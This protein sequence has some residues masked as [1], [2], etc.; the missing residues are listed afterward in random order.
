MAAL[1]HPNIVHAFSVDNESGRATIW[2]WSTSRGSTWNGWWKRKARWTVDRAAEYI[3]QAADG[4]EHAHQ[5]NMIHCN[6]KPSNLLVNVQGVVK[7]LDM[8]L[9]RLT[10]GESQPA[11]EGRPASG[12]FARQADIHALGCTFYFLLSGQPPYPEVPPAGPAAEPPNVGAAGYL[13]C[14]ARR[15]HRAG[16]HL[17]END[18]NRI[19]RSLCDS[20]GGKSGVG[21]V[22]GL[23][24]ATECTTPLPMARPLEEP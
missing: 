12:S 11:A 13:P 6:I 21:P 17:P 7:I 2:S 5:R 18:G 23:D 19:G 15:S 3:R 24:A 9:A 22:A 14:A 4:L 16:R 20:R 1:D 8:G 10:T